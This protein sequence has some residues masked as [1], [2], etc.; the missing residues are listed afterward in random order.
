MR[1]MLNY[2]I[3]GCP[4][5]AVYIGRLVPSKRIRGSKWANPY[6]LRRNASPEERAEVIAKYELYLYASG[7]IRDCTD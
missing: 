2:K 6:P 7:L 4:D 5:D 3:H 1:R